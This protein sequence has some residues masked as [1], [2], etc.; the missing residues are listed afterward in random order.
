MPEPPSEKSASISLPQASASR[1]RSQAVREALSVSGSSA[2]A[3]LIASS[4]MVLVYLH[5]FRKANE[6]QEPI[7]AAGIPPAAPIPTMTT[8]VSSVAMVHS[9][10]T[11]AFARRYR[12]CTQATVGYYAS[13]D[14]SRSRAFAGCPVDPKRLAHEV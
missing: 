10:H 11:R 3:A 5:P 12:R 8:S 13:L 2:I 6:K 4:V 14:C 1:W 7:S 9:L